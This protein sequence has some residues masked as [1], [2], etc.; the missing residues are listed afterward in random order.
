MLILTQVVLEG[1]CKTT[2]VKITTESHPK[3]DKPPG[4]LGSERSWGLAG[5][6]SQPLGPKRSTRICSAVIP[7]AI[8][9]SLAASANEADPQT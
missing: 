7:A 2:Y 9:S 3:P 8:S 1:P 5:S 6:L 4:L